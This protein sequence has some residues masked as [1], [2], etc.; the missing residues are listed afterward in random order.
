MG[1]VCFSYKL[2]MLVETVED[3]IKEA[4]QRTHT[5]LHISVIAALSQS[6]QNSLKVSDRTSIPFTLLHISNHAYFFQHTIICSFATTYYP[7]FVHV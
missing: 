1:G 4:G 6:Q 5:S 3:N 2:L 7:G